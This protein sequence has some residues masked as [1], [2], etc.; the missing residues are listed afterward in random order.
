MFSFSSRNASAFRG[1]GLI[2]ALFLAGALLLSCLAML[3]YQ[4]NPLVYILFALLGNA[5]VLNGF[6]RQASFFDTFIGIFFWL[7]FFLKLSIR[8]AFMDGRFAE[9]VGAFDGSGAAFDRALWVS[10]IAFAGLLLASA[11]RQRL[12]SY[13]ASAPD[14]SASGLYQFYCR[15]RNWLL[16]GF[17]LLIVLVA[18][19]NAVLGVYQRG[20]VTRATLPFGLNGVYKWLLQFGLA[21]GSALVIRFELERSR[22][23]S[24]PAIF[25]PLLESFLCNLS[26]LSRGMILNATGLGVGA[27]RQL[28]ALRLRL[29]VARLSLAAL[30]F[31][32]LFVSSVFAVNYLRA[33]T[34]LQV[35]PAGASGALAADQAARAAGQASDMT[36][37]LL[38]DRWV[39]MEGVMAVTSAPD[40]GW[41]LWREAWK[42]KYDQRTLSLYDRRFIES[43]YTYIKDKDNF[44]FISLPGMVAFLFYTGS[45]WFLF[46]GM[47]VAGLIAALFEIACYR[48]CGRNLVLC[49]LLAQVIAFRYASFGYVP[50][51][52][53][54]LFG[55]LLLN[56]VLI[57][58]AD[59]MLVK[60]YARPV[61]QQAA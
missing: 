40:L 49:S 28:Q 7:G 3:Q 12:F 8:V 27:W 52:S 54:L 2:L 13:P 29:G 48:C 30:V 60:W 32:L 35:S 26:L 24:L 43:P 6:R 59:V 56:I 34:Y 39:G 50:G 1:F 42:E 14:I 21:S 53:Y 38:I 19:S 9:A 22:T 23:M 44:H 15:H 16:I 51:Q 37:P 10:S 31:V 46:A 57:W 47:L 41:E 5:L 55:S 4:G 18:A 25:L 61:L 33:F 45:G 20:M 58:A 11:I 36:K 17:A